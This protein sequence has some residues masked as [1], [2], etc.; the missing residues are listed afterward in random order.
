MIIIWMIGTHL[1][2]YNNLIVTFYM[3]YD[4][5]VEESILHWINKIL[6]SDL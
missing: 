1:L 6:K 4:E 2:M 5:T 3:P